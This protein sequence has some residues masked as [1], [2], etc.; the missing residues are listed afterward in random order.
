M[1][2]VEDLLRAL[3]KRTGTPETIMSNITQPQP[4]RWAA[5]PAV[6]AYTGIPIATL[7]T[8]R[9][10]CPGRIPFHRIGR[11]VRYDLNEV[12][13]ALAAGGVQ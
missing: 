6:S 8:W 4:R 12:D 2:V 7:A 1:S 11:S 3:P 5:A 13:A 10:N 9:C